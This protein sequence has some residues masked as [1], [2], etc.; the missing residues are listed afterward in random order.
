M[1]YITIIKE[2]IMPDRVDFHKTLILS[3]EQPVVNITH[4]ADADGSVSGLICKK[5]FREVMTISTNHGKQINYSRIPRGSIVIITDFSLPVEEMRRLCDN[6]T[7]IWIDH[8]Q[9]YLDPA[10]QE[11]ANLEGY[12]STE[13]AGCYLAW[14]YLFGDKPVPRVVQY[15]SDYDIW[16]FKYP[17]SL[18]FNYGLNLYNI[19][20]SYASGIICEKLF[21]DDSFIDSIVKMGKRIESYVNTRN[22]LLCKYNGFRTKVFDIPAVAINMRNTSSKVLDPLKDQDHQLL[23]TYGYNSSIM[24]YRCSL[25]TDEDNIDCN[26]LCKRLGGAGHKS[27]A[28]CSCTLQ[29]LPVTLPVRTPEPPIEEDYVEQIESLHRSDPLIMRY[30]TSGL[31]SLVRLSGWSDTFEGLSAYFINN[32]LWSI[33]AFYGTN[34]IADYDLAVFWS[35]SASGWYRYRVYSLEK[36]H[37]TPEELLQKIPGGIIHGSSVWYYRT[38][39]PCDPSLAK[40]EQLMANSSYEYR[41]NQTYNIY[42][43]KWKNWRNSN[44]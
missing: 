41:R 11:F 18:A 15:V 4:S 22:Q 29:T 25:Y 24:K 16:E 28:G 7:V 8:H 44:N 5:Y 21:Q 35:M 40:P 32:P 14:K 20:P 12:R 3:Q 13:A 26:E 10:Y 30:A 42:N 37:M 23:C 43:N 2:L 34:M 6:N 31:G 1:N 19:L 9:V 38:D 27:A 17:E 33:D 36:N 39:A